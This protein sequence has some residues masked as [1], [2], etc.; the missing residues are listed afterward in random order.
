MGLM[1]GGN[2]VMMCSGADADGLQV[3]H[4]V[5]LLLLL[6]SCDAASASASAAA[7]TAAAAVNSFAAR[8][9]PSCAL[10]TLA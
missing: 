7:A 4:V 5:L 9:T 1:A 2:G 3:L 8:A 10:A 6:F